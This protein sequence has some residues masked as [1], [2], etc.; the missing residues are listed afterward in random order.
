MEKQKEF[1]VKRA[2]KN[3]MSLGESASF[4]QNAQTLIGNTEEIL[5]QLENQANLNSQEEPLSNEA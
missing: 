4:M 2:V 1:K 5:G 3:K